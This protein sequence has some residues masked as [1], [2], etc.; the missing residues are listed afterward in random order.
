MVCACVYHGKQNKK[1]DQTILL[2]SLVKKKWTYIDFK[3]GWS[4]FLTPFLFFKMLTQMIKSPKCEKCGSS[5]IYTR[6]NGDV[7]CRKCGYIKE[8]NDNNTRTN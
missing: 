2:P 8:E 4:L 3:R 1:M 7:V 6:I 5:F